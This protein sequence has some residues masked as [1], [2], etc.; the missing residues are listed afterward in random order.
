MAERPGLSGRFW[1]QAS[2]T[3]SRLATSAAH[4]SFGTPFS[5]TEI[6][7]DLCTGAT[8]LFRIKPTPAVFLDF[9]PTE[10]PRFFRVSGS[11]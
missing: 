11:T 8:T 3:S 2:T 9:W 10:Q 4:P 6:A 1:C 7:L 5:A